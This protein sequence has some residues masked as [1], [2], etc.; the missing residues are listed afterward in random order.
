MGGASM[1]FTG[2][3]TA[4][5]TIATWPF[6]HQLCA[7]LGAKGGRWTSRRGSCR[8]LCRRLPLVALGMCTTGILRGVGDARRAMYVTLGSAVAAA[9]FDPVLIFGFWFRHRRRGDLDRAVARRDDR[10]RLARRAWGASADPPAR[11]GKARGSCPAV[12]QDRP[13]GDHDPDRNAGRQRLCDRGNG[14]VR[15]RSRG[16]LGHRRATS[17]GR[18]RRG[19]RPVRRCRP[20]PRPEL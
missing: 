13:S 17:S 10:G 19:L 8:S 14:G 20:D 5:I 1:V 7:L 9:I 12:L 11:P 18:V 4:A 3:A 2:L 6:L 15:R 16:G